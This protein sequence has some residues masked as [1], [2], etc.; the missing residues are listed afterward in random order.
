MR[1]KWCKWQGCPK[2]PKPCPIWPELVCE[3]ILNDGHTCEVKAGEMY[4]NLDPELPTAIYMY[5]VK[6]DSFNRK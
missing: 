5:R 1:N 4:W 6:E 3:F 2:K